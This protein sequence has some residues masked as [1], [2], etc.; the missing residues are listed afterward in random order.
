MDRECSIGNTLMLQL[1]LEATHVA[2]KQKKMSLKQTES[3][4][5]PKGTWQ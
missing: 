2:W 4:I 3:Q 5:L 1:G